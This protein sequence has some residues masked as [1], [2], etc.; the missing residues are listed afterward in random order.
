MKKI[1]I[2]PQVRNSTQKWFVLQDT[3]NKNTTHFY[4][5]ENLPLNLLLAK[6][7]FSPNENS[8]TEA[9]MLWPF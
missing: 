1:P 6:I 5:C 4:D 8:I 7:L 3:F 9:M 2:L